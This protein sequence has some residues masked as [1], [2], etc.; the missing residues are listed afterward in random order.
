M[1]FVAILYAKF[2]VHFEEFK[3]PIKIVLKFSLALASL[4][5][6]PIVELWH[7]TYA[8]LQPDGLKGKKN[9]W[10]AKSYKL[11]VQRDLKGLAM[12]VL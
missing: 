5:M 3:R 7:T 1:M 10:A 12:C 11:N 9:Q 8:R 2:L 4:E 6:E